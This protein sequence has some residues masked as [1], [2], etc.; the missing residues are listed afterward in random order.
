MKKISKKISKIIAPVALATGC[1][2][3][4]PATSCGNGGAVK[5]IAPYL[6]EI[7][8]DDY[9]EDTEY[10]TT[11]EAEA[12]GCSSVRNG[13][14]YGR[15]FDYVFN[16]T[17]EFI[18]RVKADKEKNRHESI[19]VAT[20]FG[21]REDKLLAGKYDKQ[22]E[23]IPN[24]T[25]DGIN[26]AGVICSSNVVSMEADM[27]KAITPETNKGKAKDLHMLFIPRFVLDNASSAKEAVEKLKTRN[28]M[29]NLNDKMYL[30]IMIADKNETRI[31]EF[32]DISGSHHFEIAET[33]YP[34]NQVAIMTN[35]Y[36]N[37]HQAKPA[38]T[39]DEK[40]GNERYQILN[41]YKDE[42]KTFD[43]M[44]SLMKRV[45]FSI[46]FQND[47]NIVPLGCTSSDGQQGSLNSEWYSEVKKQTELINGQSI[48]EYQKLSDSLN[49]LKEKYWEAREKQL[50]NPPEPAFWQTTHNSTYDMEEKHLRVIVQED[51][52]RWYDY[53]L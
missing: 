37:V 6:H 17:P 10:E 18:V 22:L 27:G 4:I 25:L 30:H 26:D 3:T 40:F 52:Q 9:R 7:T 35:Y 46:A 41:A 31:L 29:G 33:I 11:K 42:A 51:Y 34:K 1:L 39:N 47:H 49:N 13:N 16:D 23:L 53:Y 20:H 32:M 28:I 48:E 45:E 43:G 38:W 8:Y 12:F 50:R 44:Q 5:H 2:A 24:L 14:F 15:N 21:L 19:G 36:I